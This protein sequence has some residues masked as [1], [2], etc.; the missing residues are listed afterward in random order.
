VEQLRPERCCA[1]CRTTKPPLLEVITDPGV[2]A[3]G[4]GM[5]TIMVNVVR[6]LLCKPCAKKHAYVAPKQ[7]PKADQLAMFGGDDG[8]Q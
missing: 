8:S 7:Q 2:K 6:K 4:K 1:I 5:S 3:K